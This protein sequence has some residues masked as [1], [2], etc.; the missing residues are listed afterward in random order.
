MG[1]FHAKNLKKKNKKL[2]FWTKRMKPILRPYLRYCF[3][4]N[5]MG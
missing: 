3:L 2:L 1:E 4:Y 5:Y